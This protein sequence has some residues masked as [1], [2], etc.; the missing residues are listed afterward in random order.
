MPGR[1]R[2]LG[3]WLLASGLLLFGG[4]F[5][6]LWLEAELDPQGSARALL[7]LACLVPGVLIVSA[8]AWMERR[9]FAPLRHLRVQVTRLVAN[10]DARE[11]YP[12][13]GWLSELG[14]DLQRLRDG[15]RGDRQAL[16]TAHA[17]GARTA[18][19]I[20]QEL[21][22]LLQSLQVPLLL[23]DRHRRLLLFNHAAET[24]F[25]GHSPLGLGRNLAT[26][27]PSTSLRETLATLPDDGSPREVL[28]PFGDRWLRGSLRRVVS[29]HGE[30]LLTLED[31]TASWRREL[32]ERVQLA[33]LMPALRR[34]AASLATAVEALEQ[35]YQEK[36][37][38]EK[39]EAAIQEE[40]HGLGTTIERL[41]NLVETLATQGERLAPTWSN[42]L[43]HALALRLEPNRLSLT[44]IGMPAWFKADGPALLPL[45]QALLER[46][47]ETTGC[48]EFE[49][50]V[51]LGNRR[52]YLDLIWSGSPLAQ[53][54]L[55]TWSELPLDELPLSPRIAD[56]LRQ[57]DSDLWSL[58]DDDGQHAR[59]RLPLPAEARVGTP[60]PPP[61]PRPEFHDFDI[62]ELPAPE[63]ELANRALRQLE[64]VVFDTE[65]TGLEL[66]NGDTV[67]S[68]GAC[69]IV[70][71]RLLA[72]DTFD[73]LVDPQRSIPP[74]STV[75][76]GLTDA[77][78][79][80]APPLRQVLPRFR[81]YVEE[82]VLIAHNAAFDL[83]AIHPLGSGVRFDNTVLDTLLLSR[84]LDESFDDHDLDSL[85]E[86]FDLTVPPGARHSA[87]GDARITGAL[88]LALLP[89]LEAQGITTLAQ[90]LALQG[91]VGAP[92]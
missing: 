22:T 88:W 67:I 21:E 47:G 17:E 57:H 6:A 23:C 55:G 42:D 1:Q 84:A 62:A 91:K 54:R 70:N 9:L 14:E 32:T 19:R 81:D 4:A 16:H 34:H 83:R 13:E 73:Q 36:A 46:L 87:L 39:L 51:C 90:A 49:G 45:L 59:L 27:L 48:R 18:A 26:L 8:G 52:A 3:L 69:R 75:F 61:P 2:L 71:G 53:H 68:I 10:P 58:A 33:E 30:T 79:A 92:S 37:L 40:S 44:P 38:R 35:A 85:A 56:I 5:L 31:A 24:L 89:R 86:R 76:H 25:A 77:D 64:I 80:G 65:T 11:D 20:R 15:W 43:W 66:A 7:W 74:Q 12:P 72:D 28:I 60:E 29:G 78:V 50:E 63:S 82:A 41:G